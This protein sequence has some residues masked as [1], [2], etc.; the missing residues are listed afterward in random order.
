MVRRL[1]LLERDEKAKIGLTLPQAHALSALRKHGSLKMQ[2]LA[3]V[4]GLAQS[5]VTRLVA[6]LKRV[7]LLDSRPDRDDGRA[8]R[9]FLTER[10]AEL[11]D[12][13]EALDRDL[14]ERLLNSLPEV[15]RAEAAIFIE[16]LAAAVA[17]LE[18]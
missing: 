6:P 17:R 13:A 3:L 11:C 12:H 5:T 1:Q 8:T 16:Q 4:L 15:R 7:D 18:V 14:Y 10:G 9:V 2:E